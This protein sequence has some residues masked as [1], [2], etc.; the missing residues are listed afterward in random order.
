MGANI[1]HHAARNFKEDWLSKP[2]HLTALRPVRALRTFSATGQGPGPWA[3]RFPLASSS[4]NVSSRSLLVE[5]Y[6]NGG[7]D[8]D[9][10]QAVDAA[11]AGAVAA[12]AAAAGDVVEDHGDDAA[13]MAAAPLRVDAAV[14]NAAAA[15]ADGG[16]DDDVDQAVDAA[17][18][19]AVAAA[20]AAAA[21]DVVEDH[22]DDEDVDEDGEQLPPGD[23][24]GTSKCCPAQL[25][26]W[27]ALRAK[28][29]RD[30]AHI[31]LQSEF[32]PDS[33]AAAGKIE[34]E[35][36]CLG[37]IVVHAPQHKYRSRGIPTTIPCAYCGFGAD[38]HDNGM[39]S[40]VRRLSGIAEDKWLATCGHAAHLL[41]VQGGKTAIYSCIYFHILQS[42][43]DSTLCC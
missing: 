32:P 26:A 35:L 39:T 1:G 30:P 29:G 11:A 41:G 37:T 13:G 19:A 27:K 21:G 38:V 28:I 12:A 36:F 6:L 42:E 10:D 4:L 24:H 2:T 31:L 40:S 7:S 8:D 25:G 9:V 22:G 15:A 5:A 23:D 43:G 16:S 20:A 34:P 3:G 33:A 18:A 14:L 17:A